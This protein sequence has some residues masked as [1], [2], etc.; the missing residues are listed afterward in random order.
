[1]SLNERLRARLAEAVSARPLEVS[2]AYADGIAQV[3]ESGVVERALKVGDPAPTFT[4]PDATGLAV[5]FQD[6]LSSGPAIVTF[7]RGGWCPYCNIELRAY[8]ERM[9]EFTA[10]GVTLVAISPETPD[11]SLTFTEKQG[12]TF[13]VLSD[14]GN[15]VAHAFGIV[16]AVAPEIQTIYRGN[17]IDL[18]ERNAQSDH[19][20]TLP[21]PATFVVDTT[22]VIRFAFVS[23]DYTERAEPSAVIATALSL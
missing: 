18:A 16:H 8:Q 4:L 7:Y 12:L 23:A 10:A 15:A 11:A 20:I 6:L 3:R 14:S 17:G 1:V 19:D 22:G 9:S 13:P 5:S 21:L 2:E